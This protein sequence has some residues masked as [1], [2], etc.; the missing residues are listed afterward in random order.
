VRARLEP[1]LPLLWCDATLI[2]Q[3]LANLIDNAL[4]YSP[5]DTPVELLVR[6]AAPPLDDH[7]VLAV[8]DRGP[9]I[10]P[11]WR[12]R[13][14][15]VFQRGADP[16]AAAPATA[17]PRQADAQRRGGSGVGLAVCR[18]I[19]RA[20]GGDLTL[21]ARGHGGCSFEAVLPLHEPPARPADDNDDATSPSAAATTPTSSTTNTTPDRPTTATSAT[22]STKPIEAITPAAP[23][24]AAAPPAHAAPGRQDPP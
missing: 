5:H 7:L 13:V 23:G 19:A 16:M 2:S 12:S 3:L 9:G 4:A 17:E 1:G 15:E 20:H 10:A 18:A 14:F 8:R 21:R 22:T 24:V 11:A 6:R